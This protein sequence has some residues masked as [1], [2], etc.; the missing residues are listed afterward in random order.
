MKWPS[1]VRSPAVRR[2]SVCDEDA[3]CHLGELARAGEFGA[4]CG[5]TPDGGFGRVVLELLERLDR[6]VGA[7]EDTLVGEP[8]ER[9]EAERGMVLRPGDRQFS[10]GEVDDGE[11]LSAAS[12]T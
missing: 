7:D 3:L 2:S 5:V 11:L 1:A 8:D 12:M 4:G 9:G 6:D 10:V